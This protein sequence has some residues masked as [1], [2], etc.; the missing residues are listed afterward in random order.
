MAKVQI[1]E[2]I[3]VYN[4]DG[5][6]RGEF[7]YLSGRLRKTLHCELCDITHSPVRRK[8]EWDLFTS[9]MPVPFTLLHKNELD[10]LP[11]KIVHMALKSPP[12]VIAVTDGDP[13]VLMSATDLAKARS[14]VAIFDGILRNKI[15]ARQL[16]LP[17]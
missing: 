7:A 16:E 5:G 2:L 4:A 11:D 3:G 17:S 15:V 1:Q 13:V 14:D 8:R 6:F 9:T 12:C 10:G